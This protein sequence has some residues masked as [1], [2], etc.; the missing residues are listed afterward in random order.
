MWP[1]SRQVEKQTIYDLGK[2]HQILVQNN[3]WASLVSG[4]Y[5]LSP[6]FKC[7]YVLPSSKGLKSWPNKFWVKNFTSLYIITNPLKMN[8]HARPETGSL[9]AQAN[10]FSWN[11]IGCVGTLKSKIRQIGDWLVELC[12]NCRT[13][14]CVFFTQKGLLA[15]RIEICEDRIIH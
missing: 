12:K 10:K 13:W 1:P 8:G 2:T 14:D 5:F 6:L 11:V 9:S 4:V 15:E 7:G 3:Q